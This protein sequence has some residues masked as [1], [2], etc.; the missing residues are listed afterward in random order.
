M[1][2]LPAKRET[3]FEVRPKLKSLLDPHENDEDLDDY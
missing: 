1:K 3:S 2:N